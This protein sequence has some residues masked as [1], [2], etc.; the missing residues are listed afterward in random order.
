MYVHIQNGRTNPDYMIVFGRLTHMLTRLMGLNHSSTEVGGHDHRVNSVRHQL[1]VLKFRCAFGSA[2]L[3]MHWGAHSCHNLVVTGRV[4]ALSFAWGLA[5]KQA[6]RKRPL[7]ALSGRSGSRVC[8]DSR[9]EVSTLLCARSRVLLRRPPPQDC[10]Q[11][12][13]SRH[14]LNSSKPLFAPP[15]EP[16]PFT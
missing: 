13:R 6:A 4:G 1:S 11:L 7:K 8:I 5:L 12:H 15:V 2:C 3:L 9:P 14:G 16:F 10:K